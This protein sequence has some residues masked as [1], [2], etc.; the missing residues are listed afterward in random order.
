MKKRAQATNLLEQVFKNKE[1][2]PIYKIPWTTVTIDGIRFGRNFGKW[3]CLNCKNSW[4][5]AFVLQIMLHLKI[6]K[7]NYD[8]LV[9]V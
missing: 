6:I 4:S 3:K 2:K 7:I 1:V 9:K 8:F 5:S